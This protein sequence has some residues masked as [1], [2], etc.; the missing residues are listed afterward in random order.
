M[1]TIIAC[2]AA[3]GVIG[4]G[5]SQPVFLKGDLQRFKRLTLGHP[6]VMGRKTFEAIAKRLG[7]PLPERRNFVVTRQKNFEARG[8][9]TFHSLEEALAA[10]G[11][12]DEQVFVVGGAQVYEQALPLAD[13]LE[14]TRVHASFEGDA[15]F[16]E[17]NWREWVE[18]AREEREEGGVKYSFATYRRKPRA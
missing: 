11:A 3:N 5:G 2:V 12:F 7:G 10:A 13:R 17:V 4:K 8:C 15:F 6:V 14:L 16:P 18:E 9:E 1:I